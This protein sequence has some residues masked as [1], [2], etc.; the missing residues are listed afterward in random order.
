MF[1]PQGSALAL[2]M[3]GVVTDDHDLADVYKR[4]D[5]GTLQELHL[6]FAGNSDVRLQCVQDNG[7]CELKIGMELSLIHIY[8][9]HHG[10]V[11][12]HHDP[13]GAENRSEEA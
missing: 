8:L 2:L 7:C 9:G 1:S 3:L 13:A 4:Q 5:G 11:H 12:G 6:I 10:A